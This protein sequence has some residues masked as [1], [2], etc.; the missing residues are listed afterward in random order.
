MLKLLNLVPKWVWVALVAALS[1]T[2]CKLK[3]DKDGLS[4]E[5]EKARTAMAVMEADFAAARVQAAE[6][7]AEVVDEYRAKERALQAQAEAIR[8]ESDAQ[9][10]VARRSADALRERLRVAARVDTPDTAAG[11]AR[12]AQAARPE[13]FAPGTVGALLRDEAPD[14][15]RLLVDEAERADAI[16]IDLLACY[17][18]YDAALEVINGTD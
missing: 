11:S 6:R 16:R 3:V 8:R 12:P 5:I 18:R 9:V 4:I 7:F 15:A 13:P 14:A 1:A 2:S 17:A 10:A